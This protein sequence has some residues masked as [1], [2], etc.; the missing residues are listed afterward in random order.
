M[1]NIARPCR[2][3]GARISGAVGLGGKGKGEGA[4]TVGRVWREEASTMCP[5]IDMER[6]I[7]MTIPYVK[8]FHDNYDYPSKR[9]QSPSRIKTPFGGGMGG[10]GAL[11]QWPPIEP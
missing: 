2:D 8:R 10:W 1:N 9:R 5:L 6:H 11:L 7:R 4:G 3:P